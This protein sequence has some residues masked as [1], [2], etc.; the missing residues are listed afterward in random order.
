MQ[1]IVPCLIKPLFEESKVSSGPGQ[2]GSNQISV[3]NERG[4]LEDRESLLI[5]DLGPPE[6][7]IDEM[8]RTK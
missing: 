1:L 6:I 5:L 7:L 4:T 3:D 8:K 2:E